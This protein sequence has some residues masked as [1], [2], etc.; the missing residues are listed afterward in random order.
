M[1]LVTVVLLLLALGLVKC[2]HA[3]TQQEAT[4][5]ILPRKE[6][7]GEAY[8][9]Q[10][11]DF[12]VNELYCPEAVMIPFEGNEVFVTMDDAPALWNASWTPD[13]GATKAKT[14]ALTVLAPSVGFDAPMILE[15]GETTSP[16]ATF[17]VDN[18]SS[19]YAIC[20]DSGFYKILVCPIAPHTLGVCVRDVCV[21]CVF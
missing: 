11:W 5:I 18:W 19:L 3:L 9:A 10:D 6:L 21:V 1:R 16:T 12:M 20:D 7:W 13:G 14:V 4:D 15:V 2:V 8:A 17:D